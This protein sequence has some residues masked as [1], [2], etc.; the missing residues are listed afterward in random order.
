MSPSVLV[1]TSV[2]CKA[3]QFQFYKGVALVE[4]LD[5][6]W[7]ECYQ[8]VVSLPLFE[9]YQGCLVTTGLGSPIQ[10]NE[11]IEAMGDKITW[12]DVND[13]EVEDLLRKHVEL[14]PID[15]DVPHLL[16]A[17]KVKADLTVFDDGGV[18]SRRDIIKRILGVKVVNPL[19]FSE[20]DEREHCIE[21]RIP[22]TFS[23]L[24]R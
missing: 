23:G 7:K 12:A 5:R 21:S 6:M 18:E 16:A 15:S 2:F 13:E 17:A 4:M 24:P 10:I 22:F 8:L 1:D 9:E 14:G 11:F 3:I 19:G 20:M